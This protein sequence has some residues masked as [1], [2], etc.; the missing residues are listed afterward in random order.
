M[1]TRRAT[2]NDVANDLAKHETQCAERWKTAFNRF[3]T[4][5]NNI[6]NVT[7][8]V[9]QQASEI[10]SWLLGTVAFLATSLVSIII[11]MV[12]VWG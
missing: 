2:T 6:A 9:D 7:I 12:S 8:Q 1:A 3:D 4:I 5:D 10:K 11:T